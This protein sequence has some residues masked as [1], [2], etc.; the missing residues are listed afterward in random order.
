MRIGYEAKRVFHNASGLGNYSRNL[1]RSMSLFNPQNNYFLYN[2]SQGKIEFGKD[3]S[4]VKEVQSDFSNP[5]LTNLWR[6]KLIPQR[7]QKDGI[8]IFHGLSHELPYG[9]KKKGIPSVVTIHDLIF[10]RK[11]ELYSS[12]DRKVYTVK[13]K[14]A[15]QQ[16]SKIVA[17]S[18]QTKKDLIKFLQIPA[19]KISVI[20][21]GC[22]PLFWQ[23]YSNEE[24]K[25]TLSKYNLPAK[26]LLFVGTLEERKNVIKVAEAAKELNVPLVLIGRKTP[27]WETYVQNNADTNPQIYTPEVKDNMDLAKIY[28]AASVF[29]YPSHFEGFGIPV[30]EALASKT[31]VVT[32]TISSLPEVAGPDSILVNPDSQSEI[33]NALRMILSSEEL[34]CKMKKNG[35]TFAQNFTDSK[36]AEQWQ[37]LYSS[38]HES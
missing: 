22:D 8:D 10:I 12:I 34:Q 24:I 36:I 7:A 11:P 1:I 21:Q 35:Y 38:L 29:V 26:F 16:A 25:S 9:L 32:S 19:E 23:Y 17:T 28:K 20:Y 33:N 5:V 27:Y 14:A 6:Q 3:F 18:I 2:P 4:N 15:C 30:L 13:M 37:K 31:P